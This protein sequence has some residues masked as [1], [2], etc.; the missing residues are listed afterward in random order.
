LAQPADPPVQPGPAA[1]IGGVFINLVVGAV[2]VVM[3]AALATAYLSGGTLGISAV[4]IEQLKASWSTPKAMRVLEVTNGLY[5]TRSGRPVLFVVGEVE[6]R[7]E[8]A[9]LG[10]VRAEILEGDQLVGAVEGFA[11]ELAT[12]EELYTL[13]SA[14]EAAALNTRSGVTAVKL[15]PGARAPFL[16]TFAEYPP[17]L[18]TFR[19]KVT[20][21][22]AESKEPAEP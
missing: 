1:R 7:G 14:A 8:R 17:E 22:P 11:G 12:P 21:T 5:E 3:A 9:G 4:S 15:S 20:V 16:L 19:V 10:K 18:D 6:N 2:L 13:T